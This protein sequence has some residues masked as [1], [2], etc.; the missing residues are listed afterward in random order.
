MKTIKP[1][2]QICG[3]L[4]FYTVFA[5]CQLKNK[6][7]SFWLNN[8][9]FK[10]A[11]GISDAT[12]ISKKDSTLLAIEYL[13][14]SKEKLSIPIIGKICDTVGFTYNTYRGIEPKNHSERLCEYLT[15]RYNNYLGELNIEREFS[16]FEIAEP[17]NNSDTLGLLLDIIEKIE[18]HYNEF[19]RTQESKIKLELLDSI[20]KNLNEFPTSKRL[21]YLAA[22]MN[23]SLNPHCSLI[24]FKC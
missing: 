9:F 19:Y 12:S 5:S 21:Q 2:K 23:F 7:N 1:I 4:L 6:K 10:V 13:N 22:N 15:Y 20:K 11:M 8:D 17:R 3:V 24:S 14:L 16:D 18:F